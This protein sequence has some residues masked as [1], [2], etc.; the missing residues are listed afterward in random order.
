MSKEKECNDVREEAL[1]HLLRFM[2]MSWGM[3][4][5]REWEL[6][7]KRMLIFYCDENIIKQ[8]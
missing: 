4:L 8:S 5:K 6:A 1:W 7:C 2:Q 3:A